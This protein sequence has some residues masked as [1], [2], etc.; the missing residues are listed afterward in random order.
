MT[1]TFAHPVSMDNLQ[2][3]V[4]NIP[5]PISDVAI[6]GTI[7]GSGV[8][9]VVGVEFTNVL[10]T[11]AD[12]VFNIPLPHRG[13]V[14]AMTMRIG[15]RVIAADIKER[16]QARIEFQEA[17]ERGQTAA[18]FEQQRAEIFTISV[19]S[20]QPGQN[21]RVEVVVHDEVAVDGTEA[22]VR[23]PTMIKERFVPATVP[24]N[25][26]F[27]NQQ[28]GDSIATAKVHIDFSSSVND[29]VC[30]TSKNVLIGESTVSSAAFAM[31]GDFALRWTIPMEIATAKWIPDSPDS[32]IGTLEVNIRVPKAR[33]APRRKKAIQIMVDRS[34][35]MSYHYLEWA[36]HVAAQVIAQLDGDD[37]IHVATFDSIIEALEATQFGFASATRETKKKLNAELATVTARGGTQ[38]TEALQAMGAA[39]GTLDDVDDSDEYE[40]IAVLITD[41]AYGDEA[42]AAY[43]RE[44]ELKGTRVIAVAIG[45]N[46]N[47]YLEVLAANGVCC[48]IQS[49]DT[50]HEATSKVLSR[51]AAPALRGVYVECEGLGDVTPQFRP[52]VYPEV[53][54]T[55]AGRMP[56]PAGNTKVSVMSSDGLVM[57]IPV[58]ESNDSS[59]TTRWTGNFIK[60]LDYQMMSS[61]DNETD[62]TALEKKIVE[63]S[64]THKVLSKYTAWL[65]IDTETN[66][67]REVTRTVNPP[68]DDMFVGDGVV[69]STLRSTSFA[70][71]SWNFS[72]SDFHHEP[73][74]I[75]SKRQSNSLDP[76]FLNS[77][78]NLLGDDELDS[79]TIDTH[80]SKKHWLH[81]LLGI[82]R[83]FIRRIVWP[84]QRKQKQRRR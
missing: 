56:R 72:V 53:L 82:I 50:V 34:G 67:V 24:D 84:V 63:L 59:A 5:L 20:L 7:D 81:R 65:A 27:D 78:K 36:R 41:G 31:T 22:S 66:T 3:L 57:E 73:R 70:V 33:N 16:K 49:E 80:A 6:H 46:A 79:V 4:D 77:L 2:L 30:D 1:T 52:D 13:A 42:T 60:S 39:F 40:R 43:H 28:V 35:S 64:V 11:V 17:K 47:G 71:D 61:V 18:L 74:Q 44:N 45:E 29:V 55:V 76:A 51:I 23:F 21:I 48:F 10:E 38:L 58:I 26:V 75:V 68:R 83:S 19:G 25:K 12:G 54:K 14:S 15:D 62:A 9:W 8:V 32:T 69:Y 37:M